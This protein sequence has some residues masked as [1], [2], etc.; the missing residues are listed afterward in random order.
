LYGVIDEV[1]QDTIV[2]DFNH[3]MAGEDLY[4]EGEITSVG[5]LGQ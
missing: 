1:K 2:I 4:F 3:P 5:V